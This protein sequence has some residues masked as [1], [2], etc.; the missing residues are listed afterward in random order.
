MT[1][2]TEK[3]NLSLAN[4]LLI[5]SS[6][7]ASRSYL[8]LGHLSLALGWLSFIFN[9]IPLI[10]IFLAFIFSFFANRLQNSHA[11]K[12]EIQLLLR[13]VFSVL[14]LAL[15]TTLLPMTELTFYQAFFILA[16]LMV[17][18]NLSEA[19]YVYQGRQGLEIFTPAKRLIQDIFKR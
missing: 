18:L 10:G 8:A 19:Y 3:L 9:V 12:S 1:D 16:L 11:R 15:T 4:R 17:P 14:C 6:S 5:G 2:I 13:I 7:R